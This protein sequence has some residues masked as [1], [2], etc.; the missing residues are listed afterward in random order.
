MDLNHIIQQTHVMTDYLIEYAE[1]VCF[2]KFS[3]KVFYIKISAKE[4]NNFNDFDE[5]QKKM[6]KMLTKGKLLNEEEIALEI[7]TQQNS[8]SWVDFELYHTSVITVIMAIFVSKEKYSR[9]LQFHSCFAIPPWSDK[10]Y[11]PKYMKHISFKTISWNVKYRNY[12]KR[13]KFDLNWQQK[14]LSSC[15]KIFL[16]KKRIKKWIQE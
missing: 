14:S 11:N 3:K 9:D 8:I 12:L 13:G 10:N 5:R 15:W 6:T 7:A 16:W 1:T 4:L 2:N